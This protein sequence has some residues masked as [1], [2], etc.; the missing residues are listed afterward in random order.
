MIDWAVNVNISDWFFYVLLFDWAVHVIFLIGSFMSSFLIGSVTTV[1][2]NHPS[3]DMKINCL[4]WLLFDERGTLF[5][6]V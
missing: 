5:V 1:R 3:M 2:Q 6:E 4:A